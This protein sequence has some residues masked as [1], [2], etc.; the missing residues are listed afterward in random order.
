MAATTMT[1]KVTADNARIDRLKAQHMSTPQEVDFERV[2]IM[3][4]VYEGTAGYQPIHSQGPGAEPGAA[5]RR[6][7]C[8]RPPDPIHESPG[9]PQERS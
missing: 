9:P 2:K 8:P 5:A 3:A 1:G 6:P 7:S 4:E